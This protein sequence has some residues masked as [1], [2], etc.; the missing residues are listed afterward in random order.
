MGAKTKMKVLVTGGS[1]FVG[2]ELT[3]LLILRGHD[4]INIDLVP[5]SVPSLDR[6]HDLTSPVDVGVEVDFCFHLASAAGG[7]LFNQKDV[8]SYN[9]R[10]NENVLACCSDTPILFVST[11]NVF[12]GRKADTTNRDE[13]E[14]VTLY[15]QSKLIGERYFEQNAVND[16]YIVRPSNL[17]GAS[18]L[19]KFI[20]YGESHVIPDILNKIDNLDILEVWGDGT[21]QRNF[22]H[23][24]D[25]CDYL[26]KFLQGEHK[27]V[28]NVCSSITVSIA[29]LAEDL[30][31]FRNK[32]TPILYNNS[33][34]KYENMFISDLVDVLENIGTVHSVAEGLL[35]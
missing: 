16:L 19:S 29:E 2:Q 28:H 35:N 22:L 21:Q 7:I 30:L 9:N 24:K 20:A 6:I 10:I 31:R 33:Y 12:E 17:F 11:L 23:V 14:P 32:N 27:K 34:M 3:Q 18:Q 8:I 4:V 1:G 15:A 13:L 5:S 25:L 26:M